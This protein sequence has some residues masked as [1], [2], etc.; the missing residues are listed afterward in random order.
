MADKRKRT[1]SDVDKVWATD[2]EILTWM[3]ELIGKGNV[4]NIDDPRDQYDYRKA[5]K[6][7]ARP[8]RG[9]DGEMHWPSKWKGLGHENRFV[10]GIDTITGK[11]APGRLPAGGRARTE[12]N[13][14]KGI[15]IGVRTGDSELSKLFRATK[16]RKK[17][18]VER[19]NK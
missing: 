15:R 7:G 3:E 18:L 12:M 6:S 4:K 19:Y 16:K 14:P 9:K 13:T 8:K 17:G 2:P 1:K 5:I 10:G 11:P